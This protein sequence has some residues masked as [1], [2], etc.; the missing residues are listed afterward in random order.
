MLP[1]GFCQR[2]SMTS[3]LLFNCSKYYSTRLFSKRK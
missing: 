1:V 3:D 2:I